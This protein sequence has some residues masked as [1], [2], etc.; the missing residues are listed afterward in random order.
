[1]SPLYLCSFAFIG[2]DVLRDPSA[3]HFIFFLR[4]KPQSLSHSSRLPFDEAS[5]RKFHLESAS[6]NDLGSDATG[7][8]PGVKC[9]TSVPPVCRKDHFFRMRQNSALAILERHCDAMGFL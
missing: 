7:C 1:M 8:K 4:L 2:R 6:V 5:W 3:P 9:C